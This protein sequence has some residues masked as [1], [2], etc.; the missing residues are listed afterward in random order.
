MSDGHVHRLVA[1]LR[2]R[3]PMDSAALLLAARELWPG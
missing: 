1:L 3:G 2:E